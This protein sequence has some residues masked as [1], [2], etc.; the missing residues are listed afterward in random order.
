MAFA[1]HRMVT[2]A[3]LKVFK[4]GGLKTWQRQRETD[5]SAL[6]MHTTEGFALL[7]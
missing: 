1:N 5:A 2:H 4:E 7:N 6:S 3:A